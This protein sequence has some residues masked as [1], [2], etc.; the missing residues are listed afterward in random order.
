MIIHNVL[1]NRGPRILCI[2]VSWN[3]GCFDSSL[4]EFKE[5][6]FDTF[7]MC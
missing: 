1:I 7:M 5:Q 2:G 4:E 6:M 3:T